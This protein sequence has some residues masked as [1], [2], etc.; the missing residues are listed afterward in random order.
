MCLLSS[1]ASNKF[2]KFIIDTLP[3]CFTYFQKFL[4]FRDDMFYFLL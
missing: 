1:L 4:D 2:K 3:I